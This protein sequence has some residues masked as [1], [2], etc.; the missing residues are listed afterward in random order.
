MLVDEVP[1][2]E[3]EVIGHAEEQPARYEAADPH[4]DADDRHD[5]HV[6]LERDRLALDGSIDGLVEQVRHLD[7]EDEA[8]EGQADGCEE[9][10]AAGGE[11][12]PDPTGPALGGVRVDGRRWSPVAGGDPHRLE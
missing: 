3:L 1:Q 8:Q 10:P 6:V 2:I 12:R 7:L 4:Q 5:D 9:G 11:Q